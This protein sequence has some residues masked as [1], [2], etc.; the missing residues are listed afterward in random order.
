MVRGRIAE[1]SV[2][3]IPVEWEAVKVVLTLMLAVICILLKAV[4]SVLQ[5]IAIAIVI[6]LRSLSAER[7]QEG[8]RQTRDMFYPQ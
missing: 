3:Q 7:Q 1:A 4:P 6:A 8:S 5:S 2:Q